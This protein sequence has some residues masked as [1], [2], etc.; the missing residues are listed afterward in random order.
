MSCNFALNI[1]TMSTT[2]PVSICSRLII[3][4]MNVCV[5]VLSSNMYIYLLYSCMWI[6]VKEHARSCGGFGEGCVYVI[7]MSMGMG[8]HV[9]MDLVSVCV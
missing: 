6:P 1:S 8:K 9:Q 5:S 3:V 2:I 4:C 7:I